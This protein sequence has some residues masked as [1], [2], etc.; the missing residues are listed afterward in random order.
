MKGVNLDGSIGRNRGKRGRWKAFNFLEK[1]SVSQ[2]V[3]EEWILGSAESI[4]GHT[5]VPLGKD[6]P[7]GFEAS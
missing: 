1:R 2:T 3:T 6:R 4:D 5:V 7:E